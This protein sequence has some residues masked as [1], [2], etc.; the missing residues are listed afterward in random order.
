MLP[1]TTRIAERYMGPAL[2]ERYGRRNAVAGEMLVRL[3][4]ATIS[5]YD[6]ISD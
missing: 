6:G 2:A 5:G 1:F 4:P 3:R